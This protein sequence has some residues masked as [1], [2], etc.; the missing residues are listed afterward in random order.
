MTHEEQLKEALVR[1]AANVAIALS[2]AK[3][4]VA[5]LEKRLANIR[6]EF[7]VLDRQEKHP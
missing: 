7:A 4:D 3:K 1:K 6:A 5:D 2:V